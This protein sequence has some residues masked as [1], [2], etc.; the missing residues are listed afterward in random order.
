MFSTTTIGKINYYVY[1]LVDPRTNKTFYVGKGKEN[2]V[3]AHVQ[4]ALGKEGNESDKLDLIREIH[5]AGLEVEH[6]ILR[7]GLEEKVALEVEA[8]VI[9]ALG[10]DELKN[11]VKGHNTERGKISCEELEIMMGAQKAELKHDVLAIK[12]NQLYRRDMTKNE[13]Y[14][15]TRKYWRLS[16]GNAE[17]MTYVLAVVEGIVRGVFEPK[18]WHVDEREENKNQKVKRIAFR[19]E[20]ASDEVWNQYVGKS[21]SHYS[22]T[23][24]QNP[25]VYLFE[26]AVHTEEE[27]RMLETQVEQ[28]EKESLNEIQQLEAVKEIEEKAITIKINKLYRAGMSREEL[29]KAASYCWSL[30]LERAESAQYVFVVAEGEIKEVYENMGW[31]K[32]EGKNKVA[33]NA[34]IANDS[35]REKYIGRSVKPLYKR[36]ES[37][38]CKYFNI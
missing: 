1:C 29:H 13:L 16:K 10:L 36:G 37:N 12:I 25:T 17:K 20:M 38:P 31:Y 9:D 22:K 30:T 6:Y 3:F 2:R 15:A 33:F 32:V 28:E 21:I 35:I 24:G 11:E 18:E 19:G 26:A 7:H 4:E 23:Q 14:E 8:A 27:K 34:Q 5:A